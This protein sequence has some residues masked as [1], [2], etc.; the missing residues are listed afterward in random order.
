MTYLLKKFAATSAVALIML[1]AA[2]DKAPAQSANDNT[3]QMQ[4]D[5]K[6]K[7]Y[8]VQLKHD[9]PVD[10]T[11]KGPSN[12]SAPAGAHLTYYGGRVVG[13]AQVIEVLWGSGAYDTHVLNTNTPS[14]AT[15]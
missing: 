5:G 4:P 10:K 12:A 13:S 7:Y 9:V 1:I 3:A 6:V 15:F 2:T 11:K 8:K 14:I